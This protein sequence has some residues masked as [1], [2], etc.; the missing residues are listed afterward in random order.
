[1]IITTSFEHYIT[2][3][4]ALSVRIDDELADWHL[5]EAFSGKKPLPIAGVNAPCTEHLWGLTG[6]DDRSEVLRLAG[7]ID[8]SHGPVFIASPARAI[9]DMLYGVIARDADPS[10]IIINQIPL[11]EASLLM[12]TGFVQCMH[13]RIPSPRLTAWL[14]RNTSITQRFSRECSDSTKIQTNPL[15]E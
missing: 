2:G 3:M 11:S 12:L 1:M 9:A 8:S 15:P 13:D 4:P 5:G 10:F 14:E 6:V 7:I